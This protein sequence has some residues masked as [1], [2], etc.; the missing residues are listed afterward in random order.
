MSE[1]NQPITEIDK[2]IAATKTARAEF[3]PSANTEQLV[4]ELRERSIFGQTK[5]HKSMDRKDL[6][7]TEWAQ[8][9][10]EE[11]L[12]GAE[13]ANRVKGGAV[14]LERAHTLLS[15]LTT[16]VPYDEVDEWLHDYAAQ[17]G[18][19]DEEVDA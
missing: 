5:Y 17:F 11:C 16:R 15:S 7:L 12:D 4:K 10:K 19:A 2:I 8:H 1:S 18:E 9:F 6:T 3:N 13:Y 14:L